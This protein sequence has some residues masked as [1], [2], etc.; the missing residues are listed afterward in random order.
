[1]ASFRFAGLNEMQITE[2]IRHECGHVIV[3]R[4]LG[5]PPGGIVL[6]PEG[7]GSDSEHVLSIGSLDEATEFMKRR[8]GDPR[9]IS[10]T[11]AHRR[12]DRRYS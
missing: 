2:M 12:V 7:A 9:P 6:T 3:G 5:F 8:A 1:M 4:Y 10:R 11:V